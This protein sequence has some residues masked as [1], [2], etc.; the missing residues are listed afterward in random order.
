MS[1]ADAPLM[2]AVL[3]PSEL[4]YLLQT[5]GA[6]RVVGVNNQALFPGDPAANRAL[7]QDGLAVLTE[8]RWLNKRGN[9]GIYT[10]NK[11][12]LMAAI[13]AAPSMV[14]FAVLFS[15]ADSYRT[16][17]YYAAPGH[18]VGQYIA[19]DGNYVL[20][21]FASPNA[22]VR[23]WQQA[24]DLSLPD[25]E[26]DFSL[27]LPRGEFEAMLSLARSGD[28]EAL[29]TL[30]LRH[31]PL[32]EAGNGRT[33]AAYAEDMAARIATLRPLA[34][35]AVFRYG[36]ARLTPADELLLLADARGVVWLAATTAADGW[37]DLCIATTARFA[38]EIE[39]TV[40]L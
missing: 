36:A 24:T 25:H 17:V 40:D 10:D 37:F 9:E 15:S 14:I 38:R 18:V 13:M 2:Q 32:T 39:A 16:V 5:L 33:S 8:H 21:H 4:A 3:R 20:T 1:T 19:A 27:R 23:H 12:M 35:V 28:G 7:L 11:L 34:Q 6:K 26:A 30:V 29:R 22:I 31:W